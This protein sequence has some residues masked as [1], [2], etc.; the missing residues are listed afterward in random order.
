MSLFRAERP[1]VNRVH[2][3]GT[4]LPTPGNVSGGTSAG[5]TPGDIW[6]DLTT[7]TFQS[8]TGAGQ[9]GL[10]S[11]YASPPLVAAAVT[12]TNPSSAA[13]LMTYA[14]PVGQLNAVGKAFNI[15]AGGNYTTA[16]GQTPTFTIAVTLGDGTNT[17]TLLTWTSGATTAVATAQPWNLDGT[18]VIQASG[19][20][21][22]AYAH[23][24]ASITLGTTTTAASAKY[25]DANTAVT[26]AVNLTLATTLTVT[27]LF[28]SSNAGNNV[29]ED[30]LVITNLN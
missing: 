27:A 17:R 23:G 7:Q 6:F 3:E 10:A 4:Q 18:V 13:A 21:G 24:A 22:T 26:S 29:V 9:A 14:F 1:S 28:S 11:S 16:T 12:A 20:S 8:I 5:P 30:M 15:F 25:L 2:F 19:S